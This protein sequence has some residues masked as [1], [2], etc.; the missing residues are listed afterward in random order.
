MAKKKKSIN[1]STS[2]E[3]LSLATERVAQKNLSTDI[4]ALSTTS[5][6]EEM[7]RLIHKLEVHQVEL[8]LQQEELARTR[9]ELEE[10]L[11]MYTELYDFAPVGYLTLSRDRKIQQ[12]NLTAAR[13]LGVDRSLLQGMNFMSFVLPEDNRVIDALLKT[14]CSKKVSE[15]CELKLMVSSPS[16]H[17]SD[18][19]IH[20]F[21][22]EAAVSD[23]TN[24]CR[25][26]LSD[27]TAQKVAEEGLRKSE[28]NFRSITE[29]MADEVFVIDSIGTLTYVS[30]V[31]EKLFGYLPHEVLGRPFTDY[32][33]VED[34]PEAL[35]VF[36]STLQH[37]TANQIFEVRLKRKDSSLFDG[38]IHLQY[39][40]DQDISGMIGLIR[41]ISDRKLAES[42]ARE[43]ITRYE[44]TID[45]A[46]IGTW[47]WNVQTGE[48][49]FN[50]RW[51]EIVGY[52]PEELAHDSIQ[53][54]INL[55]HPDDFKESRAIAEKHFNGELPYYEIEYRMKHKN[56]HWVWF[57]DRGRLISRTA[58]GKPLQMLGTHIDI[59]E[60]KQA[61]QAMRE[62]ERKFRSITEQISEVVFVNNSIGEVSYVSPVVEKITGYK[63]DELLGHSFF[64]YLAE[65]E[66]PR[67]T[68]IF[69]D[70][71]S[72]Q[73]TNQVVELTYRKKDGSLFQA[74][75]HS[76]YFKD[77]GSSGVIGLLRD[78]SERKLIENQL[79]KLSTA[80][81]QSPAVVL[82]TDAHGTIEY[83]NPM[84]TELTGYSIEEAKGRNPRILQSGLT[85]KSVYDELWKTFLSGRIWR[86]E[87]QNKK[88]NG[89][90]FWESVVISAILNGEGVITNFVAVKEDITERKKMLEEL[91][92]AKEKAEES[93]RLK[94]AFLAN[95]SH[96]IRTPMNGILGFSELLKEPH[97][98]GEEMSEFIELIQKSGHRMLNL[99]NDLIDISCIDAEETKVE[100]REIPLNDL[101]RDIHT[102]F[103]P[104]ARSKELRLTFTTG[105]SDNESLIK[106]DSGKLTRV[107]TNLIN[108]A[109]KFTMKGGVDFGYSRKEN[110]LEFYVIDSGIGIP[111]EMQ[112]KVFDRFHQ[113][114]NSLT[115]GY[116]GA[117]LGLSISKAL[118]KILG[119]TIHVES[120]DG[121]GTTFSFT[122]PYNPTQLPTADYPLPTAG[123]PLPASHC[124]LIVDDDSMS[125]L[126]L[127]K[128][129]KGE[130]IAILY[131]ENGWEAVELVRHHPEIN[132][133]LMDIKMPVMNGFEATRLIKQQR[134]ELPVIAQSAFTS[135]E[136]RQKARDAGCD[137]FIT[138]PIN[139]TE[140]LEMVRVLLK[141]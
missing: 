40:Q 41:D 14:V 1:P 107:L 46:Q 52:S 134:P 112:D 20:T 114:D 78:I 69:T 11:S 19:S 106:T 38:E 136:E 39:Y 135:K 131:A 62:S 76:Q 81:E 75:I 141:R 98:S 88:K 51:F 71:M 48:V 45:A 125:T 140:L 64:E 132:L 128:N 116:E 92:V 30:P 58:D 50:N 27:I 118:I 17:K 61:E 117:G 63:P 68:A 43:M 22:I 139:K 13:L 60:R 102:F 72:R 87:W 103:K 10:S 137:N 57:L 44:A 99:I 42:K 113:V 126:L 21:H 16:R 54:S 28:R 110:T 111:V 55:A 101:M 82:I 4:P 121:A 119:G 66:I 9:T 129:L 34:I 36:N 96:E 53:T 86:G 115:R 122:I 120:I 85:P 23:A 123:Y 70:A 84:F 90:L 18:H 104:D 24:A 133:V 67:A 105:L 47:D 12:A 26:I 29:Q 15:N 89:E 93:D 33:L 73:L 79:V 94:S 65:E 8:E 5:S 3:L 37:K 100:I 130:K 74:E 95:I 83:V 138:K 59:T 109:L 80:V 31:V 124:I 56:G 35:Q 6:S 7:L 97:L 127:Q 32:M 25:I 77:N 108:N 2:S 91:I 49:I